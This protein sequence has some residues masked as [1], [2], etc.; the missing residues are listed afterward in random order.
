MHLYLQ[1]LNIIFK[2]RFFLL[3]FLD[4]EPLLQRFEVEKQLD[5]I[6]DEVEILQT[7]AK[8]CQRQM[9]GGHKKSDVKGPPT[10]C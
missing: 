7:V 8:E 6:K 9:K 4:V 10:A 5:Y 2:F 1:K 3:I